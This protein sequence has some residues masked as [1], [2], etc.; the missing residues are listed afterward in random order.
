[1]NQ[2]FL[3][4]RAADACFVPPKSVAAVRAPS[5]MARRRRVVMLNKAHVAQVPRCCR[6]GSYTNERAEASGSVV[7][8]GA[9]VIDEDLAVA[10]ITEK[11]ATE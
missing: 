11:R 4:R 1:M 2:V 7:G 8:L 10:A 6:P 3:L 5:D 9:V